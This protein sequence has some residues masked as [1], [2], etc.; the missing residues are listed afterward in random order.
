MADRP[1]TTREARFRAWRKLGYGVDEAY[2]RAD[3]AGI[4]PPQ[5]NTPEPAKA[6]PWWLPMPVLLTM[7]VV[8]P[9]QPTCAL[10]PQVLMGR[11]AT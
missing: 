3:M 1:E 2:R 10:K 6:R 4:N 8:L 7:V 11:S 5:E 9:A